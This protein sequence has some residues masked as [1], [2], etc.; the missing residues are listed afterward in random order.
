MFAELLLYVKD[1]FI[2]SKTR[3]AST[4]RLS[5]FI[6]LGTLRQERNSSL[7]AVG[8]N[9]FFYFKGCYNVCSSGRL[10]KHYHCK[11]LYYNSHY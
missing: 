6:A 2:S 10:I 9:L 11:L 3:G 1:K 5:W 8:Y 7:V 4:G